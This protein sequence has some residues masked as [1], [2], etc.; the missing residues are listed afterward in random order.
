MSYS[1]ISGMYILSYKWTHRK[2]LSNTK[3]RNK[4]ENRKQ[5]QN[6]YSSYKENKKTVQKENK[7]S[8]FTILDSDSD[9]EEPEKEDDFP[10]LCTVTEKKEPICLDSYA[11]MAAR[12]LY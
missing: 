11:S 10:M 4:L 5:K 9:D 3:K 7:K 1:I 12:P 2:V 8:L 6:E